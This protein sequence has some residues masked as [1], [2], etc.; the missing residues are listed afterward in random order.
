[1]ATVIGGLIGSN[2]AMYASYTDASDN[3]ANY[4]ADYV[5]VFYEIGRYESDA[6]WLYE[7]GVIPA[8]E[9]M[10]LQS[11]R[12]KMKS[13]SSWKAYGEVLEKTLTKYY[14]NTL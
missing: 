2:A 6:K 9:Y 11:E 5:E 3:V 12:S 10:T 4:V 1:V 8:K 13:L 7:L 14:L